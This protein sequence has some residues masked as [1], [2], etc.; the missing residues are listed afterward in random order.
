MKGNQGLGVR[1][2]TPWI[3]ENILNFFFHTAVS[4]SGFGVCVN[5]QL[6]TFPPSRHFHKAHLPHVALPITELIDHKVLN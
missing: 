1:L 3:Y 2:D 6:H 5:Y 4:V